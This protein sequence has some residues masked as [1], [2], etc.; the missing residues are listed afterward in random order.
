M[1]DARERV[2]ALYLRSFIF[3]FVLFIVIYFIR[4]KG[5][6]FFIISLYYLNKALAWT[7]FFLVGVSMSLTS[8]AFFIK[9]WQRMIIYRKYLGVVGFWYFV[10]HALTSL[11][12]LK[13]LFPFPGYFFAKENFWSTVASIIAATILLAMIISSREGMV[14]IIG[15]TWWRRTLRLGF[16]VLVLIVIHFNLK[17]W[18]QTRP[19]L[20]IIGMIYV[21]FILI[22]RLILEISLRRKKTTSYEQNQP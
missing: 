17:Y 7:A 18:G 16:I 9:R 13:D 4:I 14:K 20:V 11:F 3:S 21:V 22:L 15:T 2:I 12:L 19:A 5:L 6:L 10:A 1:N 8:V